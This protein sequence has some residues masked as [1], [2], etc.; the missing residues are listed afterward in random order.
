M[1]SKCFPYSNPKQ[2]LTLLINLVF[3]HIIAGSTAV[4]KS[5]KCC[6]KNTGDKYE[7][8][9]YAGNGAGNSP[10]YEKRGGKGTDLHGVPRNSG[11]RL[12]IHAPL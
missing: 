6:N 12:G 11:Y 5:R 3:I 4:P 7:H 8:R 2:K 10:A 1:K 9:E